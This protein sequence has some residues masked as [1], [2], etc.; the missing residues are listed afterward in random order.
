MHLSAALK[1]TDPAANPDA[2]ALLKSLDEPRFLHQVVGRG[3]DGRLF[4]WSDLPQLWDAPSLARMGLP[5]GFKALT[6]LRCHF[7][8]P[9]AT[10]V[11]AHS[12]LSTTVDAVGPAVRYALQEKLTDNLVVETYTWT[13][14]AALAAQGN[15]AARALSSQT[16]SVDVAGG[17]VN[18]LKYCAQFL[19]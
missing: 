18:E 4:R 17:L 5:E 16:G 14:L 1:L 10:V 9:L 8:V 3:R 7:H 6:E 2:V 15:E 13:I 11:P 19:G 12:A